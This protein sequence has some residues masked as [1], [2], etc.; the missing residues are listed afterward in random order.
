MLKIGIDISSGERSPIEIF[1]GVSLYKREY[2]NHDFYIFVDEESY[3]NNLDYFD[4][5]KD[6]NFILCKDKILMEDKPSAIR[7]KKD[8]SI[9]KGVEFLR[10]KKIDCFFS[11]GNT[12]ALIASGSRIL[13]KIRHFEYPV[14]CVFV[15]NIHGD[16]ML[17]D[18]GSSYNIDDD[19]AVNHI[20]LAEKIY[21]TYLNKEPKVGILNIGKEPYKGP[22]WT[23]KLAK[24]LAK[25][26]EL[27]FCGFVEGNDLLTSDCNIYFT[28][29]YTGNILLK[30]IE[31]VFYYV[32]EKVDN[33][34]FLN[35]L[36]KL[37]LEYSN[38]G[39]GVVLGYKE[40]LFIGHGVSDKH[41][42]YN[43]IKFINNF[44]SVNIDLKDLSYKLSKN[45]LIR[46]I[47][48]IKKRKEER[49]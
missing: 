1:E 38:T 8:S 31:S 2:K 45:N 6:F 7:R 4:L 10:D 23:K 22:K 9:V 36:R 46:K 17:L 32:K 34:E 47:R 20:L 44:M 24:T 18:A 5:Y 35:S 13:E 28:D 33:P 12:G 25:I 21:R 40:F 3:N 30:G 27:N 48:L 49:N 19:V 37:R 14:I 39:T 29:G 26:K 42:V 43:A 16:A 41:A 15:P 11:P